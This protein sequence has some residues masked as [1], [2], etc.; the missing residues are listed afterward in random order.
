[1]LV[2][3]AMI[4]FNHEKYI[5]KALE[6]VIKQVTDFNIEIIV[7]D[8]CSNDRT[9]DIIR[10]II[11]NSKTDIHLITRKRN[12][13]ATKNFYEVLSSCKGS[14]IA[15]LEGDDYWTDVYKLQNQ[16][17]F[18]E[19]N[20]S[21]YGVSHR[22]EKKSMI[23]KTCEYSSFRG[24]YSVKD[25]NLGKLPGQTGTLCFRNF[26][27]YDSDKDYSVIFEAS[28]II[29]DRT[30]IMLILLHGRLYTLNQCM[31]VYRINSSPHSW[32]SGYNSAED[33]LAL[34]RYYV[35][36]SDYS[37]RFGNKNINIVVPKVKC[38]HQIITLYLKNKTFQN[39]ELLK[40]SFQIFDNNYIVLIVLLLALSIKKL[41]FRRGE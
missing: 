18:L 24:E 19:K 1:M 12:I 2:S 39:K 27:V 13:G 20:N 22:Y 16:I 34:L 7:G 10:E 30:I 6:S 32:S 31:S 9:V 5:R 14:Y 23:M 11:N 28:D 33:F 29:G 36:L 25:F 37:K 3:V 17:D 35:Y 40:K 26:F 15:I 21:Y 41:I 4:T 38:I 8:D